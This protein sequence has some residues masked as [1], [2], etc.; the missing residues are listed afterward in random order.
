MIYNLN[1]P[2]RW[3]TQTPFTNLT[4][5]WT[6]PEDLKD[7]HPL[8]GGKEMPF[9][10][11]ELQPEMDMINRAYIEVMMEGD[12]KG[13]VFTFPIPTYN[14]TED[15]D[16]DSPNVLTLFEN[17]SGTW[18]LLWSGI[19]LGSKI[20]LLGSVWRGVLENFTNLYGVL[21]MVLSFLQ[22]LTI[23]LLVFVWKGREKKAAVNG[24][25]AG[26]VGAAF[27]FLALGCPSCG[28]SLLAP[29]LT[30][31]AGTGAVALVDVL[32]WFFLIFAYLLLLHALRKMGYTAYVLEA[33]KR[34]NRKKGD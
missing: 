14:I 24:L 18:S 16:W 31:I 17:G 26:G 30:A 11:G 33:A 21:L 2:S 19:D 4:F 6:C 28:V 32:G 23:A 10:Y 22:G 8:I 3:G 29:V 1:V 13:R 34:Y 9:T 5:D 20:G 25:E 12:S 27:G 7:Q 15:F